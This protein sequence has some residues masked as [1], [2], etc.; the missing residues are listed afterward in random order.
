M[1]SPVEETNPQNPQKPQSVDVGSKRDTCL[2]ITFSF[3]QHR[4]SF[5][6]VTIKLKVLKPE[7]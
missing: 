1:D 2:A 6:G 4:I 7:A 5:R 3:L